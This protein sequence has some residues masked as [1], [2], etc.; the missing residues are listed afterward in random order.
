MPYLVR[1]CL[2]HDSAQ[3]QGYGGRARG[4]WCMGLGSGLG[5]ASGFYQLGITK[6]SLCNPRVT[7]VGAVLPSLISQS[8]KYIDRM[9]VCSSPKTVFLPVL[10]IEEQSKQQSKISINKAV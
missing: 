2:G 7:D 6:Y 10:T 9:C 8:N 5:R 1:N 4:R 3:G